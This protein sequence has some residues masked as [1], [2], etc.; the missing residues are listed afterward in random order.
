MDDRYYTIDTIHTYL[1]RHT[2]ANIALTN[3][4]FDLLHPGH[5]QLLEDAKA[6]AD[7]L[8]VG[9]N[10]DA[11]IRAIKGPHRPILPEATRARLVGSLK[12]V[13][14]VVV[15][16]ETTPNRLIQVIR[17]NV[18]VKGGDYV[19]DDLPEYNDVVAHGGTV[20]IVPFLTGYSSTQIIE[21]IQAIT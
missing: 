2:N 15:F 8:I 9:I 10:S 7:I 6:C 12:P 5:I 16:T 11:S 18:H 1:L 14:A 20:Q 13:D 17:P 19:A 21:R 4:C 3:G